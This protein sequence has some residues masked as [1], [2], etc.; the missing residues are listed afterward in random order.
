[1]KDTTEDDMS[2]YLKQAQDLL[3]GSKRDSSETLVP[4]EILIHPREETEQ[5]LQEINIIPANNGP[6]P[7]IEDITENIIPPFKYKELDDKIQFVVSLPEIVYVFNK[8]SGREIK[9]R[10][11]ENNGFEIQ[12]GNYLL[13]QKLPEGFNFSKV[14]CRFIL[15]KHRFKIDFYK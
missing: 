13:N 15:S 11:T 1:M 4:N 12:A 6:K 3:S 5:S 10:A 9:Y 8:E 14:D 7:L 2:E